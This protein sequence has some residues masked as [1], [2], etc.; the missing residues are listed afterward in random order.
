MAINDKERLKVLKEIRNFKL[1]LPD[2]WTF[3]REEANARFD[4]NVN[5]VPLPDSPNPHLRS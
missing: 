4:E 5:F 2:N 3:D 1:K